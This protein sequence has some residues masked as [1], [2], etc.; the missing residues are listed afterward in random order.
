M[1]GWGASL[2]SAVEQQV[3]EGGKWCVCADTLG[4]VVRM[5]SE[6]HRPSSAPS[7]PSTSD[8][9]PHCSGGRGRDK[10]LLDFL[11]STPAILEVDMHARKARVHCS[12]DL[13]VCC[14]V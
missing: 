1:K 14:A 10:D 3:G 5:R 4:H 8:S 9:P 7:T 2:T 11:V 13:W 12:N 6:R